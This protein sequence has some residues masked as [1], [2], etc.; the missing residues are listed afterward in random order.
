[1]YYDGAAMAKH[2]TAGRA[3]W[4]L[5]IV[6]FCLLV[7]FAEALGA[8]FWDN[9]RLDLADVWLQGLL[10]TVLPGTIIAGFFVW[11]MGLVLLGL[12]VLAAAALERRW[13]RGA[14]A[15]SRLSG[16]PVLLAVYCGLRIM[17]TPNPY[18]VRIAAGVVMGVA[19]VLLVVCGLPAAAA[20]ARRL[21]PLVVALI[22]VADVWLALGALG[23]TRFLPDEVLG[24]L[25]H[26]SLPVLIAACAWIFSS[27]SRQRR[28]V[29]WAAA[30]VVLAA[31]VAAWAPSGRLSPPAG[32]PNVVMIV[33]DTLRADRVWGERAV[34]PRLEKLAAGGTYYTHAYTPLPRTQQSMAAMMT[35]LYPWHN[36][37]RSLHTVLGASHTTLAERLA[38]EGYYTA[39]FVHNFWIDYGMGLEQGFAEYIDYNR[40]ESFSRRLHALLPVDLLNFTVGGKASTNEFHVD[41]RVMTDQV[42]AWLEKKPP[43]PFFLWVHYFDPHWP[44]TPPKEAGVARAEDYAAAQVINAMDGRTIVRGDMIYHALEHGITPAQVEAAARLYSGEARYTDGQVGRILD[45]LDPKST[46]VIVTA[47]HGES[48]GEH[49]YYFHHGSFTYDVCLHVPLLVAW[50]GRVPAGGVVDAPVMTVDIF[51]TVCRLL[52]MS[53]KGTDGKVLPGVDGNPPPGERW[54][55]PFTS[56]STHFKQNERTFFPGEKGKWRGTILDGVKLIAIPKPGGAAFEMY[57]LSKDPA[58]LVNIYGAG[59]PAPAPFLEALEAQGLTPGGAK[60]DASTGLEGLSGEEIERLKKLG[61]IQ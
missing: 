48:L 42:V 35:G 2:A 19:I 40:I 27:G 28:A 37:V 6:P 56:D 32:R 20:R 59:G 18:A 57:D 54:F 60:E 33:I 49:S 39:A 23:R 15:A 50:P 4:L 31:C 36:G 41:G 1:M 29:S 22:A 34:M 58:E 30:G 26:S 5:A 45:A 46:L 44:Y 17:A 24:V 43:A 38:G 14:S 53:C 25:L 10:R 3:R 9:V 47:D 7:G 13:P 16:L 8:F 52:G 21:Y 12:A 55:V 51:R 61:Y 11:A